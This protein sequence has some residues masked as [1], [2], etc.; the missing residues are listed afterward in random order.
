MDNSA[1][2]EDDV[3]DSTLTL[4]P[5]IGVSCQDL[6]QTGA[7]VLRL[8]VL[9]PATVENLRLWSFISPDAITRIG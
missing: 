4:N 2:P 5:V 6:L 3:A 8:A 7:T 1:V 9:Q